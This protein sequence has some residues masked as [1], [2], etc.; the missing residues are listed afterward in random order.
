MG[1]VDGPGIRTVLF[2]QGCR[3]RCQ[4]C[5]NPDTWRPEGGNEMDTGQLIRLFKR[6][7]PYYGATGDVTCSGGEPLLQAEFLAELFRACKRE[8]ITTCLDTAGCGNGDYGALLAHT[9]L[10]ILDV[11]H[12]CPDDYAAL[13]GGDIAAPNA[14]LRA[15]VQSG[16][17]LWI[18]HVV[19]PGL[20]SRLPPAPTPCMAATKTARWPL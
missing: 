14:F 6:Y 8:H 10:V 5:H 16:T 19:V 3:L 17:P 7:H 15:V 13:T 12:Y 9:D 11:K 1:L 20:V 4:Y 2:F 18:R